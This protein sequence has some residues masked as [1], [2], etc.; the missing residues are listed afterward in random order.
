M[1]QWGTKEFIETIDKLVH[2]QYYPPPDSEDDERTQTTKRKEKA[3]KK[4]AERYTKRQGQPAAGS[5]SGDQDASQGLPGVDVMDYLLS[6]WTL[7]N[8]PTPRPEP[9]AP[10]PNQTERVHEWLRGL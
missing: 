1:K 4:Q 6:L 10:D 8:L 9:S 3:A 5:S 2:P 7:N